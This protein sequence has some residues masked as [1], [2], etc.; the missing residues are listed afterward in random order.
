VPYVIDG[1]AGIE[2]PGGEHMMSAARLMGKKLHGVMQ[3]VFHLVFGWPAYLLFGATGGPKYGLSNHFL[4]TKPFSTALWP[5]Q[6]KK[7]VWMSDIGVVAMGALLLGLAKA[8]G[9]WA[10][11]ALYVGPLIFTNCW[12]VGYTWLQHTDV[13]VPHLTDEECTPARRAASDARTRTR[14]AS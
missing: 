5:G 12:L 7:R 2:L 13:D 8:F 4:P 3:V 10:V 14:C 11:M 6:W 1:R 9:G